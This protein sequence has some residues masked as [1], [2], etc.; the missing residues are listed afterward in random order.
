MNADTAACTA[1]GGPDALG[2]PRHDFSTN[3]N[4][5]GPCPLT[6]ACVQQADALHYPDPGYSE[7]RARLGAF[8]GVSPQRVLPMASASEAMARFTAAAARLG[9]RRVGYPAQHFGDVARQTQAWGLTPVDQPTQADLWWA[10]EPGTPHGQN[11]TELAALSPGP[12]W[13][14]DCAY[15]PLRLSG[16]PSLDDAALHQVWQLWSPNKALGLT[17]VRAAYVLAPEHALTVH[18]QPAAHASGQWLGAVQALAPSWVWGGHGVALLDA[19]CQPAVQ[20]W[21]ATSRQTLAR[22]KTRQLALC[23]TLGWAWQPSDA[24]FHLAQPVPDAPTSQA[25]ASL[26]SHLREHSG[27]KL[28]DA[29]SFGLPGWVRLGV[30]PPESQQVLHQAVLAWRQRET[31]AKSHS[32]PVRVNAT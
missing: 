10:C 30:L 5:C 3:A 31:P 29:A 32:A 15:A 1:H 24:N 11:A 12:E 25:L 16:A 19:W 21:L 9:W 26:L 18:G 28:R 22:W 6:L 20:H 14:L 2:L 13:V 23:D 17:G 7:L 8:H 27:I 4:A